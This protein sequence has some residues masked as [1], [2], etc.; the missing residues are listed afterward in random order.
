MS[1]IAVMDIE[2]LGLDSD[3]VILSLAIL[4]TEINKERY[5]LEDIRDDFFFVKFAVSDQVKNYN[6]TIDK[7]TVDWWSRQS[8]ESRK[9]SF[10]PDENIDKPVIE[11]IQLYNEFINKKCN[12]KQTLIFTRG[13]F[14]G[15]C[16]DHLHKQSNYPISFPYNSYRDVR[17]YIEC[18]AESPKNGYCDVNTDIFPEYDR[19]STIKHVPQEDVWL[20]FMMML[21]C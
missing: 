15:F 17:T 4:I 5:Y 14:D 2:S 7:S 18:M 1:K 12:P 19:N 21:S 13:S 11:G 9:M 10:I 16:L 3:S 6:R 8:V 20:D